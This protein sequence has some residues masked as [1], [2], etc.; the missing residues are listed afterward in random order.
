MYTLFCLVTQKKLLPFVYFWAYF[1]D[2]I[3]AV[4]ITHNGSQ[5]QLHKFQT[6]LNNNNNNNNN[7]ET[8]KWW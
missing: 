5:Q 8:Q 7:N 3:D 6:T 1:T 2:L 4:S